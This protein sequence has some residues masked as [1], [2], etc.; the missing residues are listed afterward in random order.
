VC[1]L[2]TGR[3]SEAYDAADPLRSGGEPGRFIGDLN[4]KAHWILIDPDLDFDL[5]DSRF[6]KILMGRRTYEAVKAAGGGGSMPGM[7]VIVITR[8]LRQ[9]DRPDVTIDDDAELLVFELRSQPGKDMCL[10]GGG[11]LFRSLAQRGP[12]DTVEVAVIPTLLGD[13]VSLLPPTSTRITL[14]LT[15]HKVP[16]RQA[17]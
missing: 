7:K 13:G 14:A 9:E 12:V 15:G 4:G 5:F 8:T 16:P 2:S 3:R 11:S 17:P 6:D 10:V 1:P